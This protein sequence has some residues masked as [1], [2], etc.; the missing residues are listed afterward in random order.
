MGASAGDGLTRRRFIQGL[1][2]TLAGLPLV[3]TVWRDGQAGTAPVGADGT[4]PVLDLH[5]LGLS[6]AAWHRALTGP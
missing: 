1:G 2:T 3:T 6:W 5:R 4:G